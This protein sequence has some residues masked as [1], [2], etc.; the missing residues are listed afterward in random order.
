MKCLAGF[1][2][3]LVFCN[4]AYSLEVSAVI[5]DAVAEVIV[6]RMLEHHKLSKDAEGMNLMDKVALLKQ[7]FFDWYVVP[8]EPLPEVEFK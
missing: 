7:K 3:F 8:S 4:S 2:L 1:L 6:D 5:P